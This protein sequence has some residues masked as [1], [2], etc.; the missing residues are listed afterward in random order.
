MQPSSKILIV[1]FHICLLIV[2]GMGIA[3]AHFPEACNDQSIAHIEAINQTTELI[4]K[5]NKQVEKMTRLLESGHDSK[6]V[7]ELKQYFEINSKVNEARG[8]HTT[9][10]IKLFECVASS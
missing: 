7:K 10:L 3:Q 9:E 5:Q 6:L 1:A 2:I 4:E 8:A